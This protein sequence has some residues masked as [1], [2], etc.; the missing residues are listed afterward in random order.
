[1]VRGTTNLPYG[2]GKVRRVAVF[3]KGEKAAEAEAAGAD[4]VGA[5]DL[6]ERIKNGWRD[7]DVLCA[8]PDMMRLVGQLGRLL[9]P[10]MPSPRSGTV[11]MD[12]GQLVRDIKSASRVEFRVEKA[13]I[14]HMP[15]GKVSLPDEH[16]LANLGTLIQALLKAKPPAAKGRYLRSIT[17]SSTM[18]PGIKVDVQKAQALADGR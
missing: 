16:L 11:T 6:V 14:V 1:M 8:T 12:I 13:G 2:T 5:E 15:I 18:G 3:A 10:R 4:V 7:F 17:L 9:G